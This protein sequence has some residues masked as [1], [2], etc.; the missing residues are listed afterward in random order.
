MGVPAPPERVAWQADTRLVYLDELPLLL[1]PARMARGGDPWSM[2][3][4]VVSVLS[5]VES[6]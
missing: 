4:F 5:W 2:R 1:A 6:P 3:N